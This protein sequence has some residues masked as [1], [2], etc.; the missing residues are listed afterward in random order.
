MTEWTQAL[1][2]LE[3]QLI[4][5]ER[6]L[7]GTGRLPDG[8]LLDAPSVGM[9][10]TEQIRAIALMQRHDQLIT[11]TLQVMKRGRARAATPY[12]S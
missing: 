7:A 10:P 11:E 8:I 9:D 4:R 6:A 1:D 5:Q 12:G 2:T 3:R